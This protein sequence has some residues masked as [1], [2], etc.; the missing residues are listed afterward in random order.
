MVT[1]RSFKTESFYLVL[2]IIYEWEPN[3]SYFMR[4]KFLLIASAVWH[5][6]T[7]QESIDI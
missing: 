1:W 4:I 6:I 3:K 7:G 5:S 2:L